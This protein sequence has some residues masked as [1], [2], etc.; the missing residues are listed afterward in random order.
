MKKTYIK[1]DLFVEECLVEQFITTSGG[2]IGGT[3]SG[4]TIS[5]EFAEPA[6]KKH[7]GLWN[8]VW[9]DE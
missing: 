2:D 8:D 1:P 9:G 7:S 3:G 4:G 5:D 6:A